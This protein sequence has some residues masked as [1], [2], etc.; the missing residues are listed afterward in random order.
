MA[1]R[2]QCDHRGCG[3]LL[4]NSDQPFLQFHGSMSEQIE[5]AD[6][7][8]E[9]RYLTPHARSKLAFCG[10]ECLEGWIEEA[11]EQSQF[12]QRDFIHSDGLY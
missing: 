8:V 11:K 6:G 12:M 4:G 10:A 1:F 3:K 5:T 7:T 2:K 9:Y